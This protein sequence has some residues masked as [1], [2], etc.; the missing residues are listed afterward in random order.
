VIDV[1]AY[2]AMPEAAAELLFHM[3]AGRAEKGGGNHHDE[4]GCI[5]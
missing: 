4:R 5:S 3:I 1:M 2:V